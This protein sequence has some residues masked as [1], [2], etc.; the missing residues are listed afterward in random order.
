MRRLILVLTFLLVPV[1][2]RADHPFGLGIMLGA[3]TGLSA[4]LYLARPIALA[5]GLGY[6][7]CCRDYHGLHFHTDVLWHPAI[8]VRQP[9]FVMPFYLGVG[10]RLLEHG[11]HDPYDDHFHFGVRAPFGILFD[12][13][14]V[15]LDVFI[16]LAVVIDLIY[17]GNYPDDHGRADINGAVGLR[18][19]F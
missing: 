15:Q 11:N 9:S 17:T 10:A 7:P 2:A 14:Q 3:P 19:Y 1:A 18:Y 16:E 12:F 8:L 13:P 4:K 5:F 6:E